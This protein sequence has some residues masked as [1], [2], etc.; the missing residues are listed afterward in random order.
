[1]KDKYVPAVFDRSVTMSAFSNIRSA[2]TILFFHSRIYWELLDIWPSAPHYVEQSI[3][4]LKKSD[5]I[6]SLPVSYLAGY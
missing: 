6:K 5:L 3:A 2:L 4:K 1:M